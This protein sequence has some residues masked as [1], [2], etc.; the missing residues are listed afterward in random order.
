MLWSCDS[1]LAC[2][3]KVKECLCDTP[4]AHPHALTHV[5]AHGHVHDQNVQFLHLGQFLSKYKV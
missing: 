5:L 4:G 3:Y 1:S 2:L